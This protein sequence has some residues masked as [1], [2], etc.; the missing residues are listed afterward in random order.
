MSA[1]SRYRS[2]FTKLSCAAC[3][4]AVE[5]VGV[6]RT[7]VAPA[8]HPPRRVI[9][10]CQEEATAPAAKGRHASDWV[11]L[12]TLNNSRILAYVRD[13]RGS[14]T[15]LTL[16]VGSAA[17]IQ[18]Q[19]QNAKAYHSLCQIWVGTAAIHSH[20]AKSYGCVT[21]DCP[22]MSPRGCMSGLHGGFCSTCRLRQP[23]ASVLRS[24]HRPKVTHGTLN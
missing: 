23:A 5:I 3:C 15:V 7:G 21:F 22:L 2:I 19:N 16:H 20:T 10:A 13:M 1:L 14:P 8:V 11:M 6:D 4:G 17:Q 18:V 9:G 24:P 12:T